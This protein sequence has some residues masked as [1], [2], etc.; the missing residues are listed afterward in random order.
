MKIVCA[1]QSRRPIT[2]QSILAFQRR[3]ERRGKSTDKRKLTERSH[4]RMYVY[5]RTVHIIARHVRELADALARSRCAFHTR[6]CARSFTTLTME[7]RRRLART[8]S[9][10][11]FRDGSAGCILLRVATSDG[12]T[13]RPRPCA[14]AVCSA[15]AG[16]S[17]AGYEQV[18]PDIERQALG[19]KENKKDRP[20]VRR[21][22]SK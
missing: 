15:C 6:Y 2:S 17:G 5:V 14:A 20:L 12:D 18:P 8:G 22:Y 21:E 4:T 10:F 19:Q 13:G 9:V 7:Q 3:S 1:R 11:L 16:R